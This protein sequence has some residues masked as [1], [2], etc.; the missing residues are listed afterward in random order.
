M[1]YMLLVYMNEQAMNDTERQQC[2]AESTRLTHDLHAKGQYVAAA[3]LHPV[4][5][6]TSV[7]VREGRSLVTDGPFSLPAIRSTSP[8]RCLYLGLDWSRA[9][10]GFGSLRSSPHSRCKSS[11][12]S[13]RKGIYKRD[14]GRPIWI[15]PVACGDG[16]S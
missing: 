12:S 4:A 7:R 6:A 14:L 2:Y 11:P 16:F 15:M 8:A 9:L 1:K 3:P 13:R 10:C 5:T